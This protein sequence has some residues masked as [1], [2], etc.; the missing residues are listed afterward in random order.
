[1]AHVLSVEK[2]SFAYNSVEVLRNVTFA[3]EQGDYVILAGPNGG[4]KT[5]L[6]KT[7]LGLTGKFTGSVELFGQAVSAFAAWG[8]IGYLPQRVNAFNPL[9]P[10]SVR[11]V[12]GLGLLAQ[13]TFPR[14]LTRSDDLKV[15]QTLELMGAADLKDKQVGELSGGQQQRVFVAR[16]LISNPELLILDEP[17]TALDPLARESFLE[18]IRRLNHGQGITIVLIT[19]DTDQIAQQ[20]NKVLY[21]DRRVVYY[22]LSGDFC[23]S[24]EMSRYS[25]ICPA[26]EPMTKD[27]R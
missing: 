7:V 21:L 17:S 16:A 5:T 3:V 23:K 20:A 26:P 12:V 6:I 4:G 14:R 1:M 24:E 11:E 22:G 8:K 15:T 13:K 19:H 2:L 18:L 27:E 9:F 10:A 25:G